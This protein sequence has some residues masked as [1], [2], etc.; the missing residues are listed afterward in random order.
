MLLEIL[1]ERQGV[2]NSADLRPPDS[3]RA[4]LG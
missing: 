1:E 4:F 3:E 2:L